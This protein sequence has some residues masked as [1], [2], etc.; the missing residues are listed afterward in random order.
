MYDFDQLPILLPIED[1]PVHTPASPF[2]SGQTCQCH[3][4]P[5]LLQLVA[6]QVSDGL[7]TP[8]EA[9]RLVAG[10]QV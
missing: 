6:Q 2:C 10:Q 7:L 5:E 8:A 3:K 4:S 1:E 9:T